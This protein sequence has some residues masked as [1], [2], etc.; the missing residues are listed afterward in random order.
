[1]ADLMAPV[2]AK[3]APMPFRHEIRPSTP[4]LPMCHMLAKA[5]GVG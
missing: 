3:K 5:D 1:L 2:N 4:S